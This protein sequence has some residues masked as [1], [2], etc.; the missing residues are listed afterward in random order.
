MIGKWIFEVVLSWFLMKLEL[1]WFFFLR[2]LYLLNE[3][4]SIIEYFKNSFSGNCDK[5]EIF[6]K[7]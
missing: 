2:K 3:K 1:D 7:C 4:W 5:Y 6:Y